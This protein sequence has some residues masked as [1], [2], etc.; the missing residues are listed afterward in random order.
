M[1]LMDMVD[2]SKRSDAAL[3]AMT[4]TNAEAFGTFYDRHE[5]DV[6]A[7]FRRATGR[8]DLA[9]DLTGE[10][11]AAALESTLRFDPGHGTARAWLFG[12]ARHELADLWQRGRVENRAR[13]R[14][15]IEPLL[16]S[17][18]AIER[19]DRLDGLDDAGLLEL[20]EALPEDQ[21]V[22]VKGR[23]VDECGYTELAQTLSCSPSVVRQRVSRGLRILRDRLKEAP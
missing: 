9:A 7:F 20:L 4:P 3:L 10:V 19:I 16:L 12:I 5:R 11:F 21:R 6:L 8:A 17:D 18:E 1:S 14:L 13:A 22:A 2:L 15:G 23:V